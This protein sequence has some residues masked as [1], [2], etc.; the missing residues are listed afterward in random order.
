MIR[1][2]YHTAMVD[3][4]RLGIAKGDLLCHVYSD[5]SREEL[6]E[7]G[8]RHGLKPEWIH[9]STMPHFDAF[10]ERLDWCGPGVTRA[11]LKEHIRTW[12]ARFRSKPP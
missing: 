10:G 11:E 12:R 8:R 5:V 1:F 4:R 7:W 3:N 9:N 6:E 2:H